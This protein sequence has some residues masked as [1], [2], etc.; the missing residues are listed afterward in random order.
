[1]FLNRH[2]GSIIAF[3]AFLSSVPPT[4]LPCLL[5]PPGS[6]YA[7]NFSI[8]SIPHLFACFTTHAGS[9]PAWNCMYYLSLF[10]APPPIY[11]ASDFGLHR[12]CKESTGLQRHE[13]SNQK[14]EK[15]IQHPAPIPRLKTFEKRMLL[16]EQ[17]AKELQSRN[18]GPRSNETNWNCSTHPESKFS[19]VR[20]MFRTFKLF[21]WFRHTYGVKKNVFVAFLSSVPP[22]C[23]PCLLHPP[24]SNYICNF[25]IFSIPHPFARFTTHTGSELHVTACMTF[26]FSWSHHPFT[27]LQ[28]LL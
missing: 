10:R 1:M 9:E 28:T 22:T 17:H 18:P 24:G 25:S 23:L 27:W 11:M 7:C 12:F 2:A 26:Q 15:E 20:S 5:H 19:C 14:E 4:C 6:N 13:T 3:V 16:K 8:F 21:A